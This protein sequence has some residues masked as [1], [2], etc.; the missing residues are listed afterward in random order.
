M[1]MYSSDVF[2]GNYAF[3]I[4]HYELVSIGS[5]TVAKTLHVLPTMACPDNR[6]HGRDFR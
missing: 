5:A 3:G 4:M 6:C 2:H 1:I